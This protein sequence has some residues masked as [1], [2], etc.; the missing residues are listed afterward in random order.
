M[1]SIKYRPEI[2]GL[3]AIA[4]LSVMIFHL[5]EH[6]LPG[7]FLG[8]DIFFVISG[9]LIT[10][11]ILTE[12]Q[13][14]RFSF[15]QFYARRIK[16]I[17]PA[18]ITV[19]ALVSL[20]ASAIFIYQDF[21]QLRKTIELATLFSSNFYLGFRQGYF[22]LSANENP[23]LHIWSLAVEEQYYLVFPLLLIG[24][25]KKLR[26]IKPLFYITLGLFFYP[27]ANFFYPSEYL[28]KNWSA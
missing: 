10:G 11:I 8:V 20:C 28:S 25:Y 15:K 18:F 4:V 3:R 9:F 27:I 17:Y 16:R 6:W 13:Q 22:D 24:C 26:Q 19:M 21:N 2:D 12:I 14:D 23:I 5:N 1:S 7:G